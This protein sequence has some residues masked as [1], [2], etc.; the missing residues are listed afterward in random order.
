VPPQ[1]VAAARNEHEGSPSDGD[2]ATVRLE[3]LGGFS[4]AGNGV[5]V[6]L[7]LSAQRLVAFLA[8]QDRPLLRLY[9]AGVLWPDANEK[10]SY[11]NL[12]SALWRLRKVGHEIVEARSANLRLSPTVDVDARR[13]L[14][15]AHSLLRGNWN[16]SHD[17]TALLAADL[18]PDW[19]DEWVVDERD[20][21]HQLR[22]HALEVLA[23]RLADGG[24]FGLAAE[25]GLAALQS[26]PLRESAN[27]TLIEVFLA[28]GNP[29]E[30]VRHYRSY[31]SLL[32]R[33]LG[34]APSERIRSLL[35]DLA[36]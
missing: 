26:N 28:E 20:R 4:L 18:L 9:V 13:A 1:N 2:G 14:A 7:P 6:D 32:A 25:A 27:R 22:V 33:E 34:L 16:P 30:A 17:G 5:A 23:R 15:V 11:A 21:L 8:L 24:S 29:T 31:R 19:Y 3:L 35:P 12:R 36:G 10:R